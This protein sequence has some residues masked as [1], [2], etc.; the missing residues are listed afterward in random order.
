MTKLQTKFIRHTFIREG[1]FYFS[2]RVPADLHDHYKVDRIVR[3]LGTSS[4]AEAKKLAASATTQLDAYWA[5]IRLTR[6]D[7]IG[8]DLRVQDVELGVLPASPSAGIPTAIAT[9]A[10]AVTDARDFYL[11]LKGKDRPPTFKAAADRATGYLVEVCGD[12]PIN[13]YSRADAL[14][15]RDFL[16]NRGLRGSSITRNFSHV[17]AIINFAI[18]EYAIDMKNPFTGVYYDRDAGVVERQPI[19][20]EAIQRV[21]KLCRTKDDDLRWLIALVSDTGMRLAEAAGLLKSD[22]HDLDG[23]IPRVEVQPHPWR[24]LK[25]ES[26]KRVVPLVG[27]SL[28]AATRIVAIDVQSPFAFLRYN[29]TKRTNASSASAALN[30]WLRD[31]VPNGCSMHSFRHSMRDR[32]RAVEC[33]S[34]IVDQIGGWTTEGVGNGYGKG[35]PIEVKQKWMKMISSVH[36]AD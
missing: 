9:P 10:I 27:S 7:A 28:W 3:A 14:R 24:Q 21:Q 30:K 35:Y 13:I 23:P 29:K 15:L 8:H 5:N 6:M 31:H 16:V 25:N 20:L 1:R 36:F 17:N 18:S 32:L 33:P 26:S 4:F 22:F 11:N 12:K 2:R 19:P 34:D